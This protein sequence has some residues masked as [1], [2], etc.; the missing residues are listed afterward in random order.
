[1]KIFNKNILLKKI[2]IVL[3]SIILLI[4]LLL[5][6]LS[7]I[8]KVWI[9][10]NSE[11]LIGRKIDLKELH[12]NY[13]KI[14]I[15]AIDFVMYE[16]NKQDTFVAFDE[17][18]VN[19]NPWRLISNE[20][21]FAEIKLVDPYVT[22]EYSSK[23]F[24][25]DD[26]IVS[27]TTE[28]IEETP[29]QTDDTIKFVVRNLNISGGK[30]IYKDIEANTNLNINDLGIN[31]PLISWNSQ[32]AKLG[33][34]FTLDEKGKVAIGGN[35]NQ[36]LAQ[37]E[38]SLKSENIDIN[39]LSNY[40]KPYIAFNSLS[41]LFYSDVVINGDM[42]QPENIKLSGYAGLK[43]VELIDV[44]NNDLL[45]ALDVKVVFDTLDV[46]KSDYRIADIEL[47]KP[48]IAFTMLK[49][50]TNFDKL[51]APYYNSENDEIIQDTLT[52][53]DTTELHYSI[54]KLTI[55][56][57][58]VT[59]SDLTLKRAFIYD[60]LD[61]NVSM[62]NFSD[63]SRSVPL[64]YN[65]NLNNNGNLKGD[66]ELDML[67]TN[68]INLNAIISAMDLVSLSPYTEYYL[69]RP[70]NNGKFDYTVNLKMNP[71]KLINNNKIK[72]SKLEFGKK[73]KD[74]TAYKVPVNLA[75]YILK[76]KNGIIGFDLPVQGS[77]SDPNFKLGKIIWKTL[78]NFLIKTA[79]QPFNSLGKIIGT[80]PES[81]KFIAFDY[82]QDS[83]ADKQKKQLDKICEII[84]KKPELQFIFK[85]TTNLEKETY[86][87]AIHETKKNY[88]QA[89]GI[90][91]ANASNIEL[92]EKL[93]YINDN[94]NDFLLYVNSNSINDTLSLEQKCVNIIGKQKVLLLF[95]ELI[96]KRNNSLKSYMLNT[97]NIPQN[98][99]AIQTTDLR[100]LPDELKKTGF[101]IEVAMQ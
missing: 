74:T 43:N 92:N 62:N 78:E 68:N 47:I 6:F 12:I 100:N 55:V 44:D 61:I 81:I 101:K 13:L 51:L 98:Q 53:T 64:T 76:D 73:T 48:E 90:V 3:L 2:Y 69:A 21:S 9:V 31:V 96:Y 39:P 59:F 99:I 22:I 1:M 65:I 93:S 17:L 86:A 66:A 7:T 84:D 28:I 27:D 50:E 83:L 15:K 60:V 72:I 26:L 19:F 24:N 82:L 18:Y 85:Q 23:G 67:Q 38:I 88:L 63:V 87:L 37:Y 35:I 80:D 25:F 30:I 45:S 95:D 57:G 40:F 29:E 36:E 5:F 56:D 97:K 41:G 20:Y 79:T 94:D 58:K 32:Q 10:K 14:S 91:S 54:N 89:K 49:N 71:S 70:V 77:P 8:V 46:G 33:I 4:F 16:K 11:S 42:S 52:I 34:D 75:L